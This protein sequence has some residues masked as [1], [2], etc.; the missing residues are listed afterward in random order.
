MEKELLQY[1]NFNLKVYTAFGPLTSILL[2]LQE[3]MKNDVDTFKQIEED[4]IKLARRSFFDHLIF[5]YTHGSIALSIFFYVLKKKSLTHLS[6]I[7]EENE[8]FPI[9]FKNENEKILLEIENDLKIF[10]KIDL[11]N[12]QHDA[13]IVQ[14]TA[15]ELLRR[16]KV[17]ESAG[18]FQYSIYLIFSIYKNLRKPME[19]IS[20]L[21]RQNSQNNPT[22]M[23]KPNNE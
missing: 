14:Q 8:Y 5:K 16:A 23:T 4:C 18:G 22:N 12:L 20:L 7:L 11:K 6:K 2:V 10:E 15:K 9:I 17:M 1:L 3:K 13:M 19:K 21:K